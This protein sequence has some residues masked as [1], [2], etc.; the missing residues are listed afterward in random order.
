MRSHPQKLCDL[1]AI[2]GTG[3]VMKIN[4]ME[5]MVAA[6]LI[7]APGPAAG[8]VRTAGRRGQPRG[9]LRSSGPVRVST[10]L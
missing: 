5:C 9:A 3:G 4:M 8:Q 1:I 10:N 6:L 2:G 7:A